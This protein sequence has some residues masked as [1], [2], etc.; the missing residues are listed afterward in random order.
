MRLLANRSPQD[1]PAAQTPALTELAAAAAAQS[2]A[3]APEAELDPP[4]N[5]L[6]DTTLNP[7]QPEDLTG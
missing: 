3:A 1:P 4:L 5:Q 2:E 7:D 6:G